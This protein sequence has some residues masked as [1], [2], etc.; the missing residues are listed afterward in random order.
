MSDT[1]ARKSG[2]V[3][4][5]NL[6][7]GYGFLTCEDSK[8][9]FFHRTQMDPPGPEGHAVFDSLVKGAAVDF[10]PDDQHPKGARAIEVR[11]V[12]A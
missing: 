2:K 10:V 6:E 9:R 12:G 5:I 7:K 11:R 8:D 3:K 1:P 4:N